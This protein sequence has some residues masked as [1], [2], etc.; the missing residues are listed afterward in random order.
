MMTQF[1]IGYSALGLSIPVVKLITESLIAAAEEHPADIELLVRDNA[2]DDDRALENVQFFVESD[3]DLAIIYHINERIGPEFY[4][5]LVPRPIIAVDIPIPLARYFGANNALA[6][7]LIGEALANWVVENWDSQVDRVLV[8]TDSRVVSV[9]RERVDSAVRSLREVISVEDQNIM[10]L[11]GG[12]TFDVSYERTKEVL[13]RWTNAQR[14]VVFG[15]NDDMVLGAYQ[16]AADMGREN[17]VILG[18]Q[19][20]D[21]QF[22]QH[23]TLPNPRVVASTDFQFSQ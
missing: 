13:E 22:R 18:G 11:D 8:L 14:I 19:G 15:V 20:A 10:Y 2:L 23:I 21:E 12:T 9:V 16:A 1:T 17:N 7:E 4:R 5:M 6:G 3:V